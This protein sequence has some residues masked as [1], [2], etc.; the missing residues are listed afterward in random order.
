[1]LIEIGYTPGQTVWG[2]YNNKVQEFTV[3]SAEIR[4]NLNYDTMNPYSP[5]VKYKLRIG[6]SAGS[7]VEIYEHDLDRDYFPSKKKLIESL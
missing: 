2:M 6:E 3:E 5:T 4:L 7:R 1:M